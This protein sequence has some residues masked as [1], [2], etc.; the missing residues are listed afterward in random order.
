MLLEEKESNQFKILENLKFSYWVYNLLIPITLIG[1]FYCSYLSYIS[2]REHKVMVQYEPVREGIM[3][4][5]FDLER[6]KL[7]LGRLLKVRPESPAELIE[8]SLIFERVDVINE[9]EE[10]KNDSISFAQAKLS[11]TKVENKLSIKFLFELFGAIL[12]GFA[13]FL[14]SKAFYM[15]DDQLEY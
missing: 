9:S 11:F 13:F 10:Y 12:F 6:R 4:E 3:L 5:K 8:L 2:I 7:E 15:P 1:F 14:L